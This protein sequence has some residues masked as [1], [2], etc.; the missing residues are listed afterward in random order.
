[1]LITRELFRF[2]QGASDQ[3]LI[4]LG[5][6]R[7]PIGQVPFIAHRSYGL[8]KQIVIREEAGQW[9]VSFC[10]EHKSDIILREP[11]RTRIRTEPA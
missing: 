11:R 4:E 1:M 5:T 6:D 7:N 8:P 9:Y 10:Y 3:M 2:V